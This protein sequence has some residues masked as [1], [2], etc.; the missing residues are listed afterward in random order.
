[1]SLFTCIPL[2]F[3]LLALLL[4]SKP[5]S[6]EDPF[7]IRAQIPSNFFNLAKSP[8]VFEYMVKIRRALHEYP[9]LGFE[10][11][12][13]SKLIRN[14]LHRMG[15]P[16][17]FP[18]AITGVVGF[19]GSGNPPFVALRADMDALPMQVGVLILFSYMKYLMGL[20]KIVFLF[21]WVMLNQEF[22]FILSKY[23]L[24]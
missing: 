1:M 23:F 6:A 9:E 18:I 8:E 2:L 4:S 10:E 22:V 24:R 12:E 3:S 17:K 11:F 14:E 5:T 21:C 20:S 15:I 13:T 7:L 19:I 16:Y